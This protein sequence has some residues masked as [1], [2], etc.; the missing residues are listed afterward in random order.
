LK[1]CFNLDTGSV[2]DH[3][4]GRPPVCRKFPSV[5]RI[6]LAENTR[7]L[8]FSP[9]PYIAGYEVIGALVGRRPGVEP[10]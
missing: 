7:E 4:R 2:D 1:A 9:W 10:K 3:G 6:G 8:V 5:R